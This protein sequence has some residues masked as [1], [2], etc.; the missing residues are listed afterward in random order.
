[1]KE[2]TKIANE[3]MTLI[4]TN[5]ITETNNLAYAGAKLVV[6]LMQAKIPKSNPSKQQP[7]VPPWKK[8]LEKQLVELRADLSK[9]N[10]MSA[11]RLQNK[12]IKEKLNEKYKIQER[13][14]NHVIEDI[15]QRVKAKSH[16][17]Q[18]YTSRN[19]GYQQ[20]KLFQTNQSQLFNQ[21][22]D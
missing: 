13:G 5:N 11:N 18:R 4:P 8:R 9:L 1:M 15:K 14:L 17:I 6:E 20:D 7:N 22:R 21:L 3:A 2:N 16:K 19:K 12:R 10:E